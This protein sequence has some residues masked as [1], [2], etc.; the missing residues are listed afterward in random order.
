MNEAV[1]IETRGPMEFIGVAVFGDL[2]SDPSDRAWS[3][4]GEIADEASIKRI[5][6]D[7][8]GLRIYPPRFPEK[9]EWTYMACVLNEPDGEIPIRMVTKSVPSLTY[10]VRKVEGGVTGIDDA[11]IH[12]YRKYLPES[13]LQVAMPFDFEKY[14][15]ATETEVVP[16]EIE[17]WVPVIEP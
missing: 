17:I 16:D 12:L 10:A 15:G 7:L 14:C 4:F 11:I 2:E 6:L 13:G 1:R 9:M 8:Y 5:G 3:L